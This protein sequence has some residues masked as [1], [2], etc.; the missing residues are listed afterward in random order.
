MNLSFNEFRDKAIKFSDET[1]GKDNKSR[2][3]SVAH[4]LI[5]ETQ[6][7]L[8]A[9]ETDGDVETEFADCFA[10]LVDCFRMHYGDDV[11]MQELINMASKKL[12]ICKTRVWEKPDENGVV[13]HVKSDK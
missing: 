9:I 4:H 1:F 2:K 6:E 10:L 8:K 11:N 13:R 3:K 5:E 7:L 12:D